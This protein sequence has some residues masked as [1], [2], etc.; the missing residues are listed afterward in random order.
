M[1]GSQAN[2]GQ[3]FEP[4]T[5]Y[6]TVKGEAIPPRDNESKSTVYPFN[7]VTETESGH[8][9][10][11][12]D[13]P[14]S[15]RIQIFHRSGTFDEIHPNGDKVE[16][17]VR[18][19]YVS[20]LRDSNVHIDGFSNV[21]VDKGLK[22]YVNRDNLQNSETSCVNFDVHV[23]QNANVNLF[24]EKGNCNV[25]LND[26]DI[27]VEM[28]KGD[29][30]FR[31]N[32]G[33]FNHFINGDYN[34]ECTGHM[35]T[36]VGQDKVT[37]IG[38]SRDTRI[39]GAFDNL[40]VTT[41]YKETQVK[42]DHRLEVMGGVYDLFHMSHETKILL[43][44]IIQIVGSNDEVIGTTDTLNVGAAQ[45][46][47]IG[48]SRSVTT[49][50]SVS[51]LT[52][53]STRETTGGTLD[54]LA[55]AKASISS[56]TMH[57]NGGSSILGSAGMIHL[58]GP[59]ASPATPASSASPSNKRPVY[60]PGPSGSW[61]KT[62]S[63]H[64]RSPLSQLQ[65]ATVDLNQQLQAVNALSELNFGVAQQVSQLSSNVG[66][67]SQTLTGPIDSLG[68]AITQNVSGSLTLAQGAAQGVSN[69][70]NGAASVAS[71]AAATASGAVT[72]ATAA[73]SGLASGVAGGAAGIGGV[74]G[75]ALA[76]ATST[77][78]SGASSLG[79]LGSVFTGIGSVLGD[80]IDAIVEVG[81]AIGEL[82]N[83]L[84]NAVVKP[85]LDTIN[86]VFGKIADLLGQI[87]KAIG[88][89]LGKIGEIIGGVLG[90]IND[91][92]GKII[93]AAGKFI[94]GIASAINGLLSNLF[95]GFKDIGCG[96]GIL[97]GKPPD[98]GNTALSSLPANIP[99]GDI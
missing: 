4:E 51:V 62:Q 12:D 49:G 75:G 67:L 11:F 1:A 22:V 17:I 84:I 19:Q 53:G 47:T 94:G 20:V 79:G 9:V 97:S 70:A 68:P 58:N 80:V 48:G 46:Q 34:L 90:A 40:Q 43:N 65:N 91:I 54:I 36:V 69:V 29:V 87:T 88:D 99:G 82:I 7:K 18:D 38:G 42:G 83:K 96:D 10:E 6:A 89:V 76:G 63:T 93:D 24:M 2:T 32:K 55:G 13:T 41:G 31:Q 66:N 85:I 3:W 95:D 35:H 25:R 27:N 77:I 33:N 16:K 71:S 57:L 5:P 86:S 78:S 50:G 28:M 74:A 73:T 21:T 14:G 15:E 39:D 61:R 44:R 56:S 52:G 72:S 98:L 30:N 59:P 45:N 60:V 81:C 23:G 37:E 64:P 92:I 26:G 8:I